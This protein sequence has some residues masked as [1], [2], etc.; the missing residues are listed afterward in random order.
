MKART[1]IAA[2]MIASAMTWASPAMS[3]DAAGGHTMW[4]GVTCGK[5]LQY[6]TGEARYAAQMWLAG[7]ITAANALT[8]GETDIINGDLPG[9][10]AWMDNW[11][12]QNPLQPVAI[13]AVALR[14]EL[15]GR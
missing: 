5:W 12:G 7:W 8:P 11:C 4:G 9:A 3:A 6:N 10:T 13:G 14:N 2:L 1:Y 15:L